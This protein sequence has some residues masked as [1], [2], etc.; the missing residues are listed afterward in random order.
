MR[1]V[2]HNKI[3]MADTEAA[4]TIH[5]FVDQSHHRRISRD[6]YAPLGVLFGNE[7]DRRGCRQMRLEG[8]HRLIDER[9]AVGKKEDALYPVATHEYV[10][11][12]ND[13]PCFARTRRHNDKGLA[14][15]I[16]LEGLTNSTDC[17]RLIVALDNLAVY[18][19][20][21]QRQPR[22]APLNCKLQFILLQEPL[23]WTRRITLVI[24]HPMLITI[25]IED[26]RTLPELLLKAIRVQ[27]G[28][29]LAL[30]R[31]ALGAFRLDQP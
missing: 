26:D 1:L 30:P 14:V 29:A 18:L 10:G 31:I 25:G 8:L 11:K 7:V 2:D 21:L 28:L 17:T 16:L 3:E 5:G 27:L 9:N 15:V 13:G 22:R 12:R 24:P 19:R 6:I 20:I 4:L 23:Y